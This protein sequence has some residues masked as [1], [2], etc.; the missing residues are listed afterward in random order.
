[1]TVE[2]PGNMAASFYT[3]SEGGD[4]QNRSKDQLKLS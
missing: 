3:D 4:K 1:M 2:E